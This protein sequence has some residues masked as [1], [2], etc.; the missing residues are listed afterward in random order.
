[1]NNIHKSLQLKPTAETNNTT[2]FLD[3]SITR[4]HNK[5]TLNIYRKPTTIHHSSN[6][7]IE[8]KTAAYR[9][10]LNRM[11]RL[12]IT[13]ELKEQEMSTIY[14]IAK[15]N[16]YTK[17]SIDKLNT[18]IISKNKGQTNNA[19][20]TQ[21]INKKWAVFEYHSPMIKKVTNIFKN[22]NLHISYRVSNT[23]Q[24]LLQN[25]NENQKNI[26]A[27]SGIYSLKC[28]T[29]DK[30]YVGQTGR[31]DNAIRNINDTSKIMNQ[32]RHTHYIY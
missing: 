16:G 31:S 25:H 21:P 30:K 4:Q 9:F 1:M 7:P 14:Q 23:T 12:P 2:N 26:D 6:H 22:T 5:L 8:H 28:N 24:K 32:N 15:K 19:P 29:C 17:Q 13:Q 20:P 3:L 18:Q 27:N 10:L 11:H